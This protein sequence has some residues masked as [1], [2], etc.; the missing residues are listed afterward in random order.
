MI[1]NATT[2]R[3]YRS[4]EPIIQPGDSPTPYRMNVHRYAEAIMRNIFHRLPKD[5]ARPRGPAAKEIWDVAF[6]ALKAHSYLTSEGRE[7]TEKGWLYIQS[8]SKDFTKF[9]GDTIHE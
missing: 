9:Q 6:R 7:L 2:G 3:G 1:L 4:H 5:F 8:H